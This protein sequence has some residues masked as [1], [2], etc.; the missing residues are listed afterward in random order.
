MNDS[1]NL[2]YFHYFRIFSQVKYK[3]ENRQT[4]IQFS[5][6]DGE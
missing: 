2:F 1:S 5:N 3:N 4:V 6:I